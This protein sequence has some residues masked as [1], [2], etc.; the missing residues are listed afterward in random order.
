MKVTNSGP[1]GEVK[2]LSNTEKSVT[3]RIMFINK[4]EGLYKVRILDNSGRLI[5]AKTITVSGASSLNEID[6]P[7]G[8][9]AGIYHVEITNANNERIRLEKL[10]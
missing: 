5:T 9:A 7:A 3:V 6:M 1:K 8:T 2:I 10:F 4:K